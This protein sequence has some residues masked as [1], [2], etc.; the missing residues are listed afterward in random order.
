MVI[1]LWQ[2]HLLCAALAAADLVARTWRI[3][4]FLGGLRQ[5]LPFGQ[6]FVQT[7]LGEAASS[8][9]PLRLGGEPARVWAMTRDSVAVTPAV[10]AIGVEILAMAPV[11]LAC[12]LVLAW[13]FAPEWW[14][15]VEPALVRGFRRGWPL[16]L[17]VAALSAAAWWLAHRI[18]PD[19]ARTLRKEI[20]A[21]RVYARRLPKWPF[22][23]SVPLTVVSVA[24]RVAILP[25]LALT[26]DVR[27]PLGAVA[28]GSFALLYSQL[29]LP[30]PAGAGA[31][32]LGFL[33]GAAGEMGADQAL[34]LLAWRFYTTAFG[35]VVGIL[36][37]LHHYG[38]RALPGLEV[39]S[40]TEQ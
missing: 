13:A 23:V 27:P 32:E 10:L 33:G 21:A 25:V 22:V 34:L 29:V 7:A 30:T 4:A 39:V 15:S 26:L 19:A 37:A 14:A 24:A 6:V 18:A 5:H 28:M 36:L 31:V 38:R 20:R 17:A 12:A 9:T 40:E 16:V 1:P 35:V 2:A 11:I 3:R 8:L